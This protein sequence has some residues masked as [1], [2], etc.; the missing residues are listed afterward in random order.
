MTS[1]QKRV[2]STAIRASYNSLPQSD[3]IFVAQSLHCK[4]ESRAHGH[5]RPCILQFPIS[6]RTDF[7]LCSSSSI[8]SN[9][10]EIIIKKKRRKEKHSFHIFASQPLHQTY[11]NRLPYIC[12]TKNTQI[13]CLPPHPPPSPLPPSTHKKKKEEK[14]L[15]SDICPSKKRKKGK[16]T[17][18]S[19]LNKQKGKRK[20]KHSDQIL[21]SHRLPQRRKHQKKILRSDICITLPP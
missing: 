5:K 21:S 18:I 7:V 8:C 1:L 11:S 17:Q 9:L 13:Q 14:E 16:S 4:S 6:L 15:R 2:T 20:I 12:L 3:Q 10:N 19:S